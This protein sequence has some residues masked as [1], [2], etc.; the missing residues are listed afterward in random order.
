M[1]SLN[2]FIMS[3]TGS[4][5]EPYDDTFTSSFIMSCS[6]PSKYLVLKDMKK[7]MKKV[8][9]TPVGNRFRAVAVMVGGGEVG[10]KKPDS[11]NSSCS[12]SDMDESWT[13]LVPEDILPYYTS[14]G[15]YSDS[16]YSDSSYSDSSVSDS[17]VSDSFVSHSSA[18][19]YDEEIQE[20]IQEEI[21]ED[22]R[23]YYEHDSI[24]YLPSGCCKYKDGVCFWNGKHR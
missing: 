24:S 17:S 14:D 6:V 10:D 18:S 4:Y 22:Y 16:S 12:F 11:R 21:H 3:R 9:A 15:S 20:E 13:S 1:S 5:P 2:S 7:D 23:P 8:A 19:S